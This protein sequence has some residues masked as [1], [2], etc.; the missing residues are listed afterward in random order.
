MKIRWCFNPKILKNISSEGKN[1]YNLYFQELIDELREKYNFT[2]AQIASD[3]GNYFDFPTG[4]TGITYKAHFSSNG[5][6][7]TA[8]HINFKDYE[9]NKTFY[10]VLIERKDEIN[11]K[12]DNLLN[13]ERRDDMLRCVISME[14]DGNIEVDQNELAAIKTWHIQSLLKFKEVFTPEIED[15]LEKLKS[16]Q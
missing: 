1:K 15:T 16:T 13:W 7:Y 5:K 14:R 6:G 2:N 12:I 8:M 4:F 9:K 11:A 10:D 3:K